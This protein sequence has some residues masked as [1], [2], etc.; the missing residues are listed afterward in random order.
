MIM[1]AIAN[2]QR[3]T[4]AHLRDTD[5]LAPAETPRPGA[6]D[7]PERTANPQ[8]TVITDDM[9]ANAAIDAIER[10]AAESVRL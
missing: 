3:T 6:E 1:R 4:L 10:E 7:L 5:A 9:D 2:P 8:R